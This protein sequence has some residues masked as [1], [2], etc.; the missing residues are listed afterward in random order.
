MVCA[1]VDPR[2]GRWKLVSLFALTAL[3]SGA[4]RA[5]PGRSI[6]VV[7]AEAHWVLAPV[8]SAVTAALPEAFTRAGYQTTLAEPDS[9]A[10]ASAV[11]DG[12]GALAREGEDADQV[13]VDQYTLARYARADAVLTC[14]LTTEG[15]ETAL[16]ASLAGTVVGQAATLRVTAPTVENPRELGRALAQRLAAAITPEVWGKLGTDPAATK[17]GATARGAAGLAAEKAGRWRAAAA[18]YE[19]ALV[20]DPDN[21]DSLLGAAR[22]LDACGAYE[23]AFLRARRATELRP[24]DAEAKYQFAEVALDAGHFDEVQAAYT[25]LLK[26]RPVDLRALEVVARARRGQGDVA[27]AEEYYGRL[28]AALPA[29][30]EEPHTLA[31]ILADQKGDTFQFVGLPADQ[32][33]LALVELYLEAGEFEQAVR[34]L[35]RYHRGGN[36]PAYTDDDYVVVA[37]GLDEEATRVMREAEAALREARGS[38]GEI[39]ATEEVLD[40]LHDRSEQLADVGE[41]VKTSD[42]LDAAHRFRV[43]AYN[44]LNESD[45]EAL[46][47]VRTND[48]DHRRRSALLRD[49]ART[50]LREATA[51]Q[52]RALSPGPEEETPAPAPAPSS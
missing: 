46:L 11:Q 26:D 31:A 16:E 40:R 32:V 41:W 25:D 13:S 8:A 45:Y 2:F 34:V 19:L 12:W 3:A 29:L 28:L 21:V 44:A 15:A 10:V 5:E 37:A 23:V 33:D 20:G 30:R 39:E 43:L 14:E 48:D 51:R 7:P 47:Y 17:A 50:A 27:G 35:Y 24:E 38:Q 9:P 4:A 42:L 36:R 52:A 1:P 22:T 6:L 49:S 18:Q